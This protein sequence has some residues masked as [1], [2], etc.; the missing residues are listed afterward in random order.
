MNIEKLNNEIS[1]LVAEH[2]RTHRI[3][4]DNAVK[5]GMRLIDAKKNIP[6]GEWQEWAGENCSLSNTARKNYMALARYFLATGEYPASSSLT[7]AI[8]I[9]SASEE[10]KAIVKEREQD[11]ITVTEREIRRLVAKIPTARKINNKVVSLRKSIASGKEIEEIE[12]KDWLNIRDEVT[13]V[14]VDINAAITQSKMR[15]KNKPSA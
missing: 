14:L 15:C 12:H 11:G 3:A 2:E 9:L 6:D 10:V 5:V 1:A 7:A 4:L 13:D 8:R